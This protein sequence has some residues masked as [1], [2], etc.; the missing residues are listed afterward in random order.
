MESDK[1]RGFSLRK[2]DREK[3]KLNETIV[4]KLRSL[5]GEATSNSI[6]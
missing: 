3:K 4:K 2:S 5:N 6:M 1:K